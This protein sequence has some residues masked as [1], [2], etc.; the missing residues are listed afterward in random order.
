LS[1]VRFQSRNGKRESGTGTGN[2]LLTRE[3]YAVDLE[4]VIEKAADT[5]TVIELNSDPHRLDM[6]WRHCRTAKDLGVPIAIGPDAHS[7]G[8]LDNVDLGIGMARKAWLGAGDVFNARSA[9][10]IIA[11]AREKRA[12]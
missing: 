11:F 2:L 3:P 4:A 10:E 12:R 7:E 6:D 9:D 5:G 8:G 1:G